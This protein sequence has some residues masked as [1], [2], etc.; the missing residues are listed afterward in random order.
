MEQW[1]MEHRK[2]TIGT[3]KNSN[4]NIGKVEN[5]NW[6]AGK[7][8]WEHWKTAIGKLDGNWIT[9]KLET[10]KKKMEHR[11]MEVGILGNRQ[12][13]RWKETGAQENW[14]M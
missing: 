4:W 8:K 2:T 14:K 5:R 6:N 13:E 12:L 1:N 3:M 7:L 10:E 11:D 9:R